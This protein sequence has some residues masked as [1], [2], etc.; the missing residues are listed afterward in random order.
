MMYITDFRKLIQNLPHRQHAF[1]VKRKN[2]MFPSQQ[3]KIDFI[4]GYDDQITINRDDLYNASFDLD[5]FLLKTLMWGY[6]TKGRGHN[7]KRILAKTN[8]DFLKELLEDYKDGDIY[9]ERFESDMQK[10]PGL[11]LS[12]M[13]KFAHFL[14]TKIEGHKALILDNRIMTTI[15][16]G[17]FTEL[18]HLKK[19]RIDNA[20]KKYP[21]YLETINQLANQMKLDPDQIELFLFM[22]GRNL[23]LK[24]GELCYDYD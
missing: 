16:K 10:I 11:G 15:N 12:T 13:S 22:F 6:P 4:F 8:F 23:S 18:D 21:L 17:S 24:T 7:L 5:S 19:I 3:D 2:W 9:I 1:D 20:I 14:N